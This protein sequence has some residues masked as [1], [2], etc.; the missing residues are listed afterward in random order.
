MSAKNLY[1][2]NG[3][4]YGI[5][6]FIGAIDELRKQEHRNYI[7]YGNSAGASFSLACYLVLNGYMDLD[8]M[9]DK[10]HEVFSKPRSVSPILTPIMIDLIDTVVPFWPVDLAQR[11]SGILN[12]GVTT[13]TG[14]KFVNQFATN[15]DIYNALLCSG[16][17]AL[18]SN[19]ESIIDGEVCLDGGYVFKQHMIP[20]DTIIIA[21]DILVLLSLTPPPPIICPLL[22]SNGR[23]NV[24]R[25]LENPIIIYNSKPGEMDIWF[26]LHSLMSKDLNWA[27]HIANMTRP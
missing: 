21:S 20:E 12:I 14:H 22:E 5:P 1:F 26:K 25:G 9:R 17:I 27:T 24:K 23:R 13:K 11:V 8:H 4:L 7:Y 3:G 19:Y 16:T 18:S 10:I 2:H 15:A 6:H